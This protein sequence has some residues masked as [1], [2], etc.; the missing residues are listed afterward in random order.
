M[1]VRGTMSEAMVCGAIVGGALAG[2]LNAVALGLAVGFVDD[3]VE[4]IIHSPKGPRDKENDIHRYD[5][6][7]DRYDL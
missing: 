3:T 7:M 4:D 1:V 6:D 2:G 5:H